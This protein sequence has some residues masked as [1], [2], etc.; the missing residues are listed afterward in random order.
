MNEARKSP[1]PVAA[2][3]EAI[4]DT[5]YKEK[6]SQSH[7]PDQDKLRETLLAEFRRAVL[8]TKLAATDIETVG[9]A[10]KHRLITVQQAM[11]LLNAQDALDW[12][13]LDRRDE[14]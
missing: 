11:E 3:R 4:K 5:L 7:P 1:A 14:R 9:V 10:L 2:G 6:N 12:L 8:R 13:S